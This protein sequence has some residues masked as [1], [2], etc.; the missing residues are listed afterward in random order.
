MPIIIDVAALFLPV[1]SMPSI[2]YNSRHRLLRAS[3]P[4]GVN[5]RRRNKHQKAGI[6]YLRNQRNKCL[7]EPRAEK[8]GK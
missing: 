2:G 3:Q 6:L 7:Q 8:N 1:T 5:R 4:D